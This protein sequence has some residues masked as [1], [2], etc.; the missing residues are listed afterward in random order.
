MSRLPKNIAFAHRTMNAFHQF[1]ITDN[2]YCT[3]I[4]S[5]T[6]G[7][8]FFFLENSDLDPLKYGYRLTDEDMIKKTRHY[9]G[10]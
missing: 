3:Y 1:L 9:F 2:I 8:T 7:Y 5:V 4:C 6:Y 10:H